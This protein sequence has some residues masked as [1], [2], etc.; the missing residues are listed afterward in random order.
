MDNPN[1]YIVLAIWIA[2][3]AGIAYY[4]TKRGRSAGKWFLVSLFL[5]PLLAYALL[6]KDPDP[7][8]RERR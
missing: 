2:V 1:I 4:A 8:L 5:S 6:N 7:T 3:S